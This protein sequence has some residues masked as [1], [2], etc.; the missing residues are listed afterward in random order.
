MLIT[1]PAEYRET[2]RKVPYTVSD[3][4]G[5]KKEAVAELAAVVRR[6]VAPESWQGN[7][8]RGT[9][10]TEAGTMT[11]VQTGDVHQQVLVFCEKLRTAR[12][13]PLRSRAIRSVLP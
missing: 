5:D 1:A 9:I 6:L 2:L 10:E 8:G 4:T 12:Q 13:K 7:G 3:L 11:V